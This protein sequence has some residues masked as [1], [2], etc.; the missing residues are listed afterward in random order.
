MRNNNIHMMNKKLTGMTVFGS[1]GM[2]AGYEYGIVIAEETG[3]HLGEDWKDVIIQWEDGRETRE[4]ITGLIEL[5]EETSLEGIGIFIDTVGCYLTPFKPD[6][7]TQEE[8]NVVEPVINEEVKQEKK[9]FIKDRSLNN[10][11]Q[12]DT[13]DKLHALTDCFVDAMISLNARTYTFV[14]LSE[15]DQEYVKSTFFKKLTDLNIVIPDEVPQ[16]AK[17]LKRNLIFSILTEY[18]SIRERKEANTAQEETIILSNEGRY[19]NYDL[20][21]VDTL[22][23]EIDT[24]PLDPTFEKRGNFIMQY[25]PIEWT[26]ENTRYKDYTVISGNFYNNSNA[27]KILTNSS[28][29]I[30]N[31]TTAIR[32]NQNSPAYKEAKREIQIFEEEKLNKKRIKLYS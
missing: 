5:K 13:Y 28:E 30:V 10:F 24:T 26:E 29:D 3:T 31:L 20:Q 19:F 14:Y 1:W 21:T 8:N 18:S 32:K 25:N 7:V 27:F 22:I 17:R 15:E 9:E 12:L 2:H 16:K 6:T 4:E 11:N 23:K